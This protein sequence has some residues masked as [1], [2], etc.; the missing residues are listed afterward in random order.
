[1]FGT[2]KVRKQ[3]N[4]HNAHMDIKYQP[5]NSLNIKHYTTNMYFQDLNFPDKL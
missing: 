4:S 2:K 5:D 1:M 3:S